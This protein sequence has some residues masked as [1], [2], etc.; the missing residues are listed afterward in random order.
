MLKPG[1]KSIFPFAEWYIW[2]ILKR[3]TSVLRTCHS[4][5]TFLCSMCRYICLLALRGCVCLMHWILCQQEGVKEEMRYI[6]KKVGS[7]WCFE[8]PVSPGEIYYGNNDPDKW[9]F[10]VTWKDSV[11]IMHAQ[12]TLDWILSCLQIL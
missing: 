6:R 12:I 7:K 1:E 3:W 9:C 11:G 8:Q 4:R 5:S 10:F 2:S